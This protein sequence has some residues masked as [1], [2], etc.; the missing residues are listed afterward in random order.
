M[1]SGQR[2]RQ[3]ANVL[4]ATTLLGLLLA[5]CART[6]VRP[7]PRGLLIATGYRWPLPFAQAFTVG[8]VVLFRAQAPE[9]LSNPVLLAHEERHS[10]QYAWCLGLPFLPLYFLAAGWSLLRTGNPGSANVFERL[11]GL[12]AG[13]YLGPHR[14]EK[15]NVRNS[16]GPNNKVRKRG[17][18]QNGRK[19]GRKGRR[20][21]GIEA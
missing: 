16:K 12:E 9:A 1:T 18:Q 11:A 13:G 2:L 6:A 10:S 21:D 20:P 15:D 17:G 3:I 5:R 8:N 14:R 19:A 4:N 7:G